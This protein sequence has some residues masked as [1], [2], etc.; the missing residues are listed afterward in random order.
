MRFALSTEVHYS[1]EFSQLIMYELDILLTQF[2]FSTLLKET[3]VVP[4]L[5]FDFALRFIES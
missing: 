3:M 5:G 4:H 2:R 1:L